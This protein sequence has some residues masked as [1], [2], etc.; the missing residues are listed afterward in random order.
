VEH[1]GDLDNYIKIG[2]RS[3]IS[4]RAK[5]PNL[6]VHSLFLRQDNGTNSLTRLLQNGHRFVDGVRFQW[7]GPRDHL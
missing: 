4:H 6:N 2:I 1:P 5:E 3:M 7:D